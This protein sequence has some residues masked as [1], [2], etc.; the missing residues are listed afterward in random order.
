MK[1]R[2]SPKKELGPIT[3]A[4]A[5]AEAKTPAPFSLIV[6][7]A[8]PLL[9]EMPAIEPARADATSYKSPQDD[10]PPAAL[11]RDDYGRLPVFQGPAETRLVAIAAWLKEN[12]DLVAWPEGEWREKY[13]QRPMTRVILE[14]E[15][16][17]VQP[18]LEITLAALHILRNSGTSANLIIEDL[19]INK[20]RELHFAV[21]I[22]AAPGNWYMEFTRHSAVYT[23]IYSSNEFAGFNLSRERTLGLARVPFENIADLNQNAFGHI[24]ETLARE[25]PHHVFSRWLTNLEEFARNRSEE[26]NAFKEMV[27]A[28]WKRSID[29]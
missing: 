7:R 10:A 6:P 21:E 25:F 27:Q 18:C 15:F 14:R 11:V 2:S 4:P 1:R 12:F 19:G 8:N 26:L 13:M 20:E 3:A 28:K 29:D 22:P 5:T 24:E 16:P 23:Y 9:R 17:C